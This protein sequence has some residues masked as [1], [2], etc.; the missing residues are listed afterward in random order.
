MQ[1]LVKIYT[2][3][4]STV[5][6]DGTTEE[7]QK[8]IAFTLDVEASDTIEELKANIQV[9]AGIAPD[10]LERFVFDAFD[11]QPVDGRTLSDYNITE[12]GLI[13]IFLSNFRR[14]A[15]DLS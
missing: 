5:R 11:G 10:Q 13:R 2:E 8:G 9:K 15:Y 7:R 14:R 4:A 12:D 1:I 3:A 6:R